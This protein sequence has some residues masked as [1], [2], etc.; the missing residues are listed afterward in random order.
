DIA[1]QPLGQLVSAA[2]SPS[3]DGGLE[4]SL[5]LVDDQRTM[6][7]VGTRDTPIQRWT[8][9]D[10]ASW[11]RI[12][13]AAATSD[14]FYVVDIGQGRML[15]Y[16]IRT[17]GAA[18]T[19]VAESGDTAD[20]LQARDLA[21]DGTSLFV[22]LPRGQIARIVPGSTPLPFD[23]SV[24]DGPL[25]DPMALFATPSSDHLWVLEPAQSRIVEFSTDGAYID[26]YILPD[27]V[28]KDAVSIHVDESAGQI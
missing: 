9:A 20:L 21:A 5:V 16:P 24:P 1:G 28:I 17:P 18:G 26:Q 23:G 19:V 15:S 3:A 7:V 13:P 2:W 14:R 4:G 11:E 22:L 6:I 12:G 25:S 27:Q 10:S 8:P